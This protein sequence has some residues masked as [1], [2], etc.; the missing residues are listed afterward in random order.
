MYLK[1][2][3]SGIALIAAIALSSISLAIEPLGIVDTSVLYVVAQ[4]LVYSASLLGIAH[5]VGEINKHFK[6]IT[7]DSCEKSQK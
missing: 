1:N 4:L 5:A 6:N 7:K 2:I 3:Y